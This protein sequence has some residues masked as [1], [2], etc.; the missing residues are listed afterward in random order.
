M[1]KPLLKKSVKRLSLIALFALG[2]AVAAKQ[3]NESKVTLIDGSWNPGEA[4]PV[5][6]QA[7][8]LNRPFGVDFDSK[9]RMWIVELEGGRVHR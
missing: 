7:N 5:T 6:T 4:G 8:P 2:Q 3:P 1:G 9:G